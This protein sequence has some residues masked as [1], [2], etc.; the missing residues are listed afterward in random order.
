M[1]PPSLSREASPTEGALGT[2]AR[3]LQ[4]PPGSPTQRACCW[5]ACP[6]TLPTRGFHLPR[7]GCAC[8]R[9]AQSPRM[10]AKWEVPPVPQFPCFQAVL[11]NDEVMGMRQETERLTAGMRLSARAPW[12]GPLHGVLPLPPTLLHDPGGAP[13][14]KSSW[15]EACAGCHGNTQSL[16]AGGWAPEGLG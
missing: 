1:L 5:P 15:W 9:A 2:E 13:P 14:S 3:K 7:R 4:G 6:R 10:A 12:P 16:W 8:C 11:Q